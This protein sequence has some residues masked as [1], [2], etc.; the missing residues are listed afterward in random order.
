M[1][2]SNQA[3][4]CQAIFAPN[5]LLNLL[6]KLVGFVHHLEFLITKK[7]TTLWGGGE[8]DIYSGGS[9]RKS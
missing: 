2:I 9:L 7:K 5:D 6:L 8:R 4:V 3:I 1:M